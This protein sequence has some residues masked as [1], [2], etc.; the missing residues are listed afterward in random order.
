MLLEQKKESLEIVEDPDLPVEAL[1]E[2]VSAF[3]SEISEAK[4]FLNPSKSDS[5]DSI[6][7]MIF[8]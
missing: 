3:K 2:L 8:K 4:Y 1:K 7:N 6:I 5:I